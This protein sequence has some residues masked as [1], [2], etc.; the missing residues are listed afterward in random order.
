MDKPSASAIRIK[1]EM[2]ATKGSLLSTHAQQLPF[3]QGEICKQC[4]ELKVQVTKLEQAVEERDK[5]IN[6]Q[7]K[8]MD[9]LRSRNAELGRDVAKMTIAIGNENIKSDMQLGD[10]RTKIKLVSLPSKIT[11]L[12]NFCCEQLQEALTTRNRDI[13]FAEENNQQ[14]LQLLEKYDLKL[15]EM[16][17][18]IEI[19]EEVKRLQSED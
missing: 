18:A 10:L 4:D 14:L 12:F 13:E 3:H 9:E 7:E 5:Q 8:T 2:N 19:K 11:K 15:D 1:P 6:E 17:E 16:H